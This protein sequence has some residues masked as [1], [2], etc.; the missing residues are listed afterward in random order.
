MWNALLYL[1]RNFLLEG[2]RMIF[3]CRCWIGVRKGG[4]VARVV[5]WSANK[6]GIKIVWSKNRYF[7]KK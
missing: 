7:H 2:E 1:F 3:Y 5:C 6:L 4:S